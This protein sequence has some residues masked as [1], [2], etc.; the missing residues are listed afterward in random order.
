MPRVGDDA[1]Y[2]H[3]SD[4]REECVKVLHAISDYT[5]MLHDEF[6][7]E[8]FSNSGWIEE[9]VDGEWITGED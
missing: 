2:T 1:K 8:D 6:L 5:L 4:S 7:M 3:E 9:N